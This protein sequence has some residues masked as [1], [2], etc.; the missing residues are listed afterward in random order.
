MTVRLRF[1][2][3]LGFAALPITSTSSLWVPLAF[4]Q[5]MNIIP[6]SDILCLA[7]LSL[8]RWTKVFVSKR[9]QNRVLSFALYTYLFN[10]FLGIFSQKDQ[11]LRRH[12]IISLPLWL[13][14]G[15]QIAF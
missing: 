13:E 15:F 11:Q 12:K 8:A 14:N 3:V 1:L 5:G 10:F 2:N 7:A 6:A 4:E 9:L